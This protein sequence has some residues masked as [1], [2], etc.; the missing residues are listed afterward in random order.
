MIN[1]GKLTPD[2]CLKA[3]S[4]AQKSVTVEAIGITSLKVC[5]MFCG[6]CGGN[7]IVMLFLMQT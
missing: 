5:A 4:I 2:S 3:R 6:T 1:S 7:L